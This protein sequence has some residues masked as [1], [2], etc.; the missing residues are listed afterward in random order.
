MSKT[1]PALQKL[2]RGAGMPQREACTFVA[3]GE[4]AEIVGLEDRWLCVER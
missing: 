1:R 4:P 3:G 2:L